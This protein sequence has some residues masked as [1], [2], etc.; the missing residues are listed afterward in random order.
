MQATIKKL[1]QLLVVVFL[2]ALIAL[3]LNWVMMSFGV[4]HPWSTVVWCAFG[5]ILLVGVASLL[6]YGPWDSGTPT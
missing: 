1:L 5:L 4:V 3:F 2:V 6:G